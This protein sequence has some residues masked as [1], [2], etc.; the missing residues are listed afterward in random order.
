[1]SFETNDVDYFVNLI[2]IPLAKSCYIRRLAMNFRAIDF[3]L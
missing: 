1:M 3:R 2:Q